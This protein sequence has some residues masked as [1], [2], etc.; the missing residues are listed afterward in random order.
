[1]AQQ[2]TGPTPAPLVRLDLPLP[3]DLVLP[4]PLPRNLVLPPP[5]PARQPPQ[6]DQRLPKH[7]P[8]PPVDPLPAEA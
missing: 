4:P 5:L 8:P 2:I 1:M 6:V 7:Q 3:R